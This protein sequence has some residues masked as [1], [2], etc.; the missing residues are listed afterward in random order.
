MTLFLYLLDAPRMCRAETH[1]WTGTAQFRLFS[2]QP[3]EMAV[4]YI[5]IP[6]VICPLVPS[7]RSPRFSLVC[8]ASSLT[9]ATTCVA[10]LPQR[11]PPCST[12]SV[13]GKSA[14]ALPTQQVRSTAVVKTLALALAFNKTF[15]TFAN[16]AQECIAQC[17]SF[18]LLSACG[19]VPGRGTNMAALSF[20]KR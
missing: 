1:G 20:G 8:R 7:A 19:K 13:F 10:I 2:N 17:V 5:Y 3:G 6:H 15:A 18:S 14:D 12:K 4:P 11:L 9:A 16:V